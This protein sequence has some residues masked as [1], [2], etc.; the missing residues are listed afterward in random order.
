MKL[1]TVPE[2]LAVER[3]ADAAGHRYADMMEHAGRGL[4]EII[5]ARFAA[6]T[7]KKILAI[8]GRGNN[9]GD[10][11]VALTHLARRGWQAGFVCVQ[12]EP[13]LLVERAVAAGCQRWTWPELGLDGLREQVENTPVLLDGLLGTGVRLPLRPPVDEFLALVQTCLPSG[14]QVVA[15]DTPSGVDCS[16]GAAAPQTLRADLTVAMAAAKVGHFAFPAAGLVGDLQVAGIGLPEG[17][18][19]WDRIR[20]V[21]LDEEMVRSWLPDRPQDAHKGTFGTALITAGSRKYVGAVLLAG[22]AA[23]RS[24]AG[25]VTTACVESLYRMLAGQFPESTWIPLPESYGAL[26]P[27]A[28]D[29]LHGQLDRITAWLVGPGLGRAPETAE[30]MRR[31]LE[32]GMVDPPLVVDADGL[33]L[34]A[35]L[36]EWPQR[37]PAETI[38]TPHPGEMAVLADCSPAEIQA[39][40]LGI[41]EAMAHH[42]GHVVVLKGAFTLVAAP[43]GRTGLVPI[44]SPALARAGT[45]D[46]L[47]G[48]I[49]GLRAQGVGAFE[50]AAAGAFLHARAGLVAERT[51]GNPSAVMAGDVLDSIARVIS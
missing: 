21:V 37:L 6:L 51:L 9:G 1:V 28:A 39:D 13:D 36:P 35:G 8:V 38:L 50:A 22:K 4:A 15:V 18:P 48:L 30:F 14:T 25:L 45:G 46:V 27:A 47:A 32:A 43:D 33:T 5:D 24:G 34:L 40:R 16:T 44:A 3:A 7:P 17:L 49:T 2:M 29:I 23:Y 42:W 41:A 10:A 31:L 19:E 12:R 20:R 26:T 11:L